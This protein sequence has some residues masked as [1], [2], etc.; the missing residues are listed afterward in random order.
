MPDDKLSG[1]SHTCD[2][3]AQNRKNPD[4]ADFILLKKVEIVFDRQ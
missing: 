1:R 3:D 2:D 4:G